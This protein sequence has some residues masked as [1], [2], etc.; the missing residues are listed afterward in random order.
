M[1]KSEKDILKERIEK[2]NQLIQDLSFVKLLIY[3]FT[4]FVV[5]FLA[6]ILSFI[7]YGVFF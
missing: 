7:L 5:M 6:I 2:Y 4:T 1:V 3:A